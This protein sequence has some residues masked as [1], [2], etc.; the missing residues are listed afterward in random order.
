MNHREHPDP[1]PF[2]LHHD[3]SQIT[4]INTQVLDHI[5]LDTD[6]VS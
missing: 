5:A 4:R 1:I 2:Y 6:K 3:E